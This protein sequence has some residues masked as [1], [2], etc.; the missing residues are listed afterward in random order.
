[1]VLAAGLLATALVVVGRRSRRL[2][3][4]TGWR[5]LAR[6]AASVVPEGLREIPGRARSPA[7]I[8]GA[9]VYWAGDCAVLWAAFHAT[10]TTPDVGVIALAYLLGQLGTTLPLPGGIGGVEPIMLGVLVASGVGAGAGAAA[11]V[12][13]RATAL[14]LQSAVGAV[15]L[16]LLIPAVRA[17]R[18]DATPR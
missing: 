7:A 17:Q 13:Y 4:R 9:A 18:A 8:G 15:A 10:G 3:G 16:S 11:I 6:E 14:G 12:V 2:V 5:R 1:V